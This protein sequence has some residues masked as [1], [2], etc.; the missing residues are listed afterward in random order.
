MFT[1]RAAVAVALAAAVALFTGACGGDVS[2]TPEGH[3]G[4]SGLPSNVNDADVAFAQSMI[5]HHEQAM[6]MSRIMLEKEGLDPRVL[7]MAEDIRQAQG[8][9]IG[10]LRGWLSDWG[11]AA[12]GM[13]EHGGAHTMDGMMSPADLSRL[14]AA[15]GVQAS[16]LFLTQ[17]IAHHQGAI[18]MAQ[19][20]IQT[21]LHAEA[22][23]M[24]TDIITLQSTDI[25]TMRDIQSS[26]SS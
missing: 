4:P 23:R 15:S 6:E 7:H 10:R 16:R 13:E 19:T 2:P 26:L 11:V 14:R 20:E 8:P 3:H 5:P 25:T 22:R 21:G 1:I 12:Q 9:E 18:R 17:M 24:A